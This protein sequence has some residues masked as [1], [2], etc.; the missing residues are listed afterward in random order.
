MVFGIGAPV[1]ALSHGLLA[2]SAQYASHHDDPLNAGSSVCDQCLQFAVADGL[3]SMG[4]LAPQFDA[5][6][7]EL[8]SAGTLA[9]LRAIAFVA[10]ASRAPPHAG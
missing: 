3:V 1:H 6:T 9:L 5:G 7:S 2:L 10:Y 4:D 8:A